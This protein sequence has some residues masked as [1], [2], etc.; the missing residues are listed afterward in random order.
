MT[1]KT[2][3]I[4]ILLMV[5]V[6]SSFFIY[7][8]DTQK[9]INVLRQ[10]NTLLTAAIEEQKTAF[11]AVEKKYAQQSKSLA[12]LLTSNASLT[13]EKESLST[14]LM[15]HDLEELSK[16]KPVLV[17]KRINDGTKKLFDSF[18]TLSTK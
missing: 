14:K 15:E 1:I 16:R 12:T 17:E 18:T 2:A 7:Y 4:A 13:I 6:S 9:T 8:A 11:A 3:I 5:T 10:N